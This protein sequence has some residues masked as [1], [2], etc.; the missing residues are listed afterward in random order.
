MAA[1]ALAIGGCA[2]AARGEPLE[3][4]TRGAYLMGTRVQL[5]FYASSRETGLAALES[6]LQALEATER[7]LSTWRHDSDLSVL[8]RHAVGEPWQANPRVCRMLS[9]VFDWQ[10]ATAGA[11][12]PAV[13]PLLA[14]WDI[15]GEGRIP[16]T[17]AL[18]AARSTSGIAL[19]ALDRSKC[20]VTRRADV[21]IDVGAFGKGE[22]LD[23]A[24]AALG[25]GPWMIDLGGQV[26]VGGPPPDRDAWTVDI[27]HPRQR[28]RAHLR[29]RMREG[30][31][32]TSG[33][34]ERSLIVNGERIA[35]H[36]DP[37]TGRPA[38][39]DGSVTVWHRRGLV[40]DAVSTALLVMGPAEGLPWAEARGFAACY[41]LSD[42]EGVRLVTTSAF[43]PFIVPEQEPAGG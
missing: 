17:A 6:A 1:L 11:F 34:S 19:L 28:D 33:G 22:G 23:R 35:H 29:V 24:E 4:V 14:A 7:E 8:N 3:L 40:A 12:D 30:S 10:A 25:D 37:R 2:L 38:A 36:L 31:L 43:R 5:T 21:T 15:H 9:E 18:A 39:F 16:S 42:G 13:G 20:T 41:L 26:S 27:A 32:S